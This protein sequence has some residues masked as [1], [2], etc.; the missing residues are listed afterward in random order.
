MLR[1]R[2]PAN[3]ACTEHMAGIHGHASI[4]RVCSFGAFLSLSTRSPFSSSISPTV[5][6]GRPF[7]RLPLLRRSFSFFRA[8]LARS[9]P[10]QSFPAPNGLHCPPLRARSHRPNPLTASAVT[11]PLQLRHI[12]PFLPIPSPSLI[13]PHALISPHDLRYRGAAAGTMRPARWR[14]CRRCPTSAPSPDPAPSPSPRCGPPLLFVSAG[15]RT[16]VHEYTWSC[17]LLLSEYS[18]VPDSG[19]SRI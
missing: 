16:L 4:L 17:Q 14:R 15:A 7:F 5:D 3:N 1:T 13:S 19:I 8:I 18:T 12:H 2:P 10:R 11:E 9:V 6:V